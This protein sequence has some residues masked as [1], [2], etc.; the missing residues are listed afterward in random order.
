[1]GCR[2]QS[3]GGEPSCPP[4]VRKKARFYVAGAD[5]GLF[6]GDGTPVPANVKAVLILVTFRSGDG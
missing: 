1:M 6:V 5:T 4:A 2:H 3:S